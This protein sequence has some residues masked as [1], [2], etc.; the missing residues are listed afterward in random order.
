MFHREQQYLEIDWNEPD[1]V[2]Y[3]DCLATSMRPSHDIRNPEEFTDCLNPDSYVPPS[4]WP[5][6][7]WTAGSA[8]SSIQACA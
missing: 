7:S 8:G 3:D 4:P 6:C 2:V 1:E 5:P